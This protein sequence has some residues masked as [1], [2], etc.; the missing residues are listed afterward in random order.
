MVLTPEEYDRENHVEFNCSEEANYNDLLKAIGY[1]RSSET[2]IVRCRYNV[3]YYDTRWVEVTQ[4]KFISRVLRE[5]SEA[6]WN[7]RYF[8]VK[9]FFSGKI[10]Y[11]EI[12]RKL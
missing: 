12:S 11:F 5:Y 4:E 8:T 10:G 2:K 3:G 9:T 1:P 6:G 7:I